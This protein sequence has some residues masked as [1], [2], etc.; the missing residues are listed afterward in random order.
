MYK[1]IIGFGLIF[2]LLLVSYTSYQWFMTPNNGSLSVTN[3]ETNI[4]ALYE[5]QNFENKNKKEY[6]LIAQEEQWQL[7]E[8]NKV[9]AWTYN[10]TVPGEP[11]RVTEGD[12]LSVKL[13]NELSEPVTIHWHGVV[14]PNVMDG[15]PDLTQ[16]AVQPGESYTYEFVADDPGTYWYH[17]HQDSAYQ[18]DKGLYGSLIVEE[19]DGPTHDNDQTLILDEWN[20]DGQ[21]QLTSMPN[22]M[23]GGM[24]GDGEADTKQLYDLY[25][26]NG[27]TGGS[28]EP[29]VIEQ[30]GQARIRIINAGYQV[31]TLLFHEGKVNV[32]AR[33]AST[34]IDTG[35]DRNQVEI[36][37][38]ERVDL[39]VT[40]NQSKPW[41]ITNTNTLSNGSNLEIPV[42]NSPDQA[43]I[44][45]AK[46]STTTNSEDNTPLIGSKNLIFQQTPETVD[47]NYNMS[48]DHGMNM[49]QGMVF[50]INNQQYPETPPIEVKEG[51]IV[52]VTIENNGRFNHPMHL[53]GHRF[54]VQSKNGQALNQPA[55]RD[56][57]NVKPGDTYTIYFKA[58]NQGE[59]LFHCHDNNHAELGMMT[60][61]DYKGVYSPFVQ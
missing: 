52:K 45:S 53:H 4:E 57:I 48:L 55:L 40:N 15:V 3:G 9:N 41:F 59:W 19:R 17:S 8:N 24:S 58:D 29:V 22:M 56:L 60:I 35:Q 25:S 28:I 7:D 54:Q 42:V 43:N 23:M 38:G 47:V 11:L 39:I 37:P 50:Q 44:G 34:T 12:V 30:D 1:K 61:V 2:I 5:Q 6:T 33:D 46:P 16:K 14:L 26:V 21:N 18:V 36:A 51:D 20:I 10:G 49:G 27:K 32:I 13:K 31:Q